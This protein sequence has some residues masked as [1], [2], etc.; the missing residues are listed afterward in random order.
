[1]FT[2]LQVW[3]V[4]MASKV[5]A[6]PHTHIT[7]IDREYFFVHVYICNTFLFI[8]AQSNINTT[9]KLSSL[10]QLSIITFKSRYIANTSEIS[11]LIQLLMIIL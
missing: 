7:V 8:K 3:A 9:Y 5:T 1:M 11:C 10:F 2:L 6:T 4:Y